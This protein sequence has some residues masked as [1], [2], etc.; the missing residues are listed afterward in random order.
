MVAGK[1]VVGGGDGVVGGVGGEAQE[2]VG[3]EGRADA[4]GVD[5]D[6]LVPHA[7][8]R[9]ARTLVEELGLSEVKASS[10]RLAWMEEDE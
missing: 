10:E 9:H 6:T 3:D 4:R 5:G 2:S 1:W 7:H 8:G